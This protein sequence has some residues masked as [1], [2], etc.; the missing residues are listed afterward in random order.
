MTQQ[1]IARR[2]EEVRS[3]MQRAMDT[4]GRKPGQVLLCAASKTQ[5]PETVALAAGLDIDLFGENR[6]QELVDK[7]YK[8]AYRGKRADMIGHLQTNKVRQTVG[9]AGMIQSVD[10][11]KLLRC[12]QAEAA[13]QQLVQ[14]VLLEINIGGEASKTGAAADLLWPM[15]EAAED[16][17]N[18]LVQGLMTV[19]PKADTEAENRAMFARMYRLFCQA[20]E[21][22]YARSR[23]EVLSMG[24][25]A[26]FEAA[27]L[28]G[29][30][31]VRVGS[32]IFGPRN[33]TV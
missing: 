4:A 18:L 22:G 28:E 27:I 24:M 8:G 12:I 16:C 33:Y 29:A 23:M 19:P 2:L 32:S 15:L 25:S 21:R 13:R 17:P 11:E 5:S 6:V 26:D 3:R 9:R 14:P 10:S 1:E 31:L 30:T 20:E 7:F